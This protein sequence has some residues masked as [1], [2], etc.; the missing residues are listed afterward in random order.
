MIVC[1]GSLTGSIGGS[2]YLKTIHGRVEGPLANFDIDYE[3]SV[4]ELC[5]RSIEKELIESAHDISNGGLSVNIA[6][7]ILNA[8]EGIVIDRSSDF[9][10]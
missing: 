1:L 9:P 3:V 4:Q 7:S 10:L 5:L 8:K 2:E 6:E